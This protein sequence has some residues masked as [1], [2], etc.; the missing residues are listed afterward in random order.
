MN[1]SVAIPESIGLTPANI[2]FGR[3]LRVPVD[4]WVGTPE[5]LSHSLDKYLLRLESLLG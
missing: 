5:D 1:A 3:Q 2:V 4:I